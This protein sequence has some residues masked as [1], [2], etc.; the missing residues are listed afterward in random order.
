MPT[1]NIL[2]SD[3]TILVQTVYSLQ[4]KL[5]SACQLGLA[6]LM[7]NRYT[8]IALINRLCKA[9][10]VASTLQMRSASHVR[11]DVFSLPTS[12]RNHFTDLFEAEIDLAG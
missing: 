3:K 7:T 1:L 8:E 12:A 4:P 2:P 5:R 6:M 10:P 11:K 9:L